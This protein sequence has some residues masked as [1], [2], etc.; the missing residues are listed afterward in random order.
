MGH[1]AAVKA[2]SPSQTGNLNLEALC[3]AL[4]HA[5]AV[6]GVEWLSVEP[7]TSIEA[8]R[9]RLR[10]ERGVTLACSNSAI[11]HMGRAY[12][13]AHTADL[14]PVEEVIAIIRSSAVP[15]A[16]AS[17]NDTRRSSARDWPPSASARPSAP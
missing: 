17:A 10:R 6:V 13:M 8:V 16:V 11:H 1:R 4:A 5:G 12:W 9:Q 3:A 7:P 15:M 14:R 2:S